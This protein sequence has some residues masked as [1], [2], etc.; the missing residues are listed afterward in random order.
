MQT[1]GKCRVSAL[2]F[3]SN[4][5]LDHGGLHLLGCTA[6]LRADEVG[7]RQTQRDLAQTIMPVAPP[8]KSL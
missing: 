7:E 2:F 3:I 6:A 1:A 5:L 4:A 8:K